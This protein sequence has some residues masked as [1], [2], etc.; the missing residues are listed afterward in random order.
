MS[1]E[2]IRCDCGK[3]IEL[4]DWG[5]FWGFTC[6][7]PDCREFGEVYAFDEAPFK[8]KGTKSSAIRLWNLKNK[9]ER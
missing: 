1:Q 2:R 5:F 6:W 4:L 7:N 9:E 8:N 3:D